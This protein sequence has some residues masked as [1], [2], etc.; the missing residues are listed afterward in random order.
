MDRVVSEFH[1]QTAKQPQSRQIVPVT[2]EST[3]LFSGAVSVGAGPVDACSQHMNADY[4][5]KTHRKITQVKEYSRKREG[6]SIMCKR[7]TSALSI[8]LRQPSEG[9]RHEIE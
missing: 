7:T 2:T 4:N 6:L 8:W 3:D 1:T 9:D 5:Q